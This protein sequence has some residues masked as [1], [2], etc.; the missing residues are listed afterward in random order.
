METDAFGEPW[1]RAIRESVRS[2]D[3]KPHAQD[4]VLQAHNWGFQLS[5][6]RA[7]PAKRSL[8]SRIF[9]FWRSALPGFSGPI[10]I[11]HVSSTTH[12]TGCC[13]FQMA[14]TIDFSAQRNANTTRFV[15]AGN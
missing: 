4:L 3:P 8:L 7:V 1:E 5:D 2:G 14:V 10:H 13:R 11:F 12:H 6:I 9:L 15:V